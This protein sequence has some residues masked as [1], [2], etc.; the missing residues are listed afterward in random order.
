[1]DPDTLLEGACS[2]GRNHYIIHTPPPVSRHL[3]VVVDDSA[4]NGYPLSIRIPL[5]HLQS[6]TYALYP[7][8]TH[9]TIRRVFTPYHAPHTKKHFC[10][11]CGTAL[12][13]WSEETPEDAEW[14]VV[15]LSSL[16][17]ESLERLQDA[18]L[19]SAPEEASNEAVS[20]QEAPRNRTAVTRRSSDREVRGVPWFEEMV[21]GSDL[22][23]IKRRRGGKT[24]TDGRT[25]YEWE[26]VEIG[27]DEAESTAT[28]TAKRKLG[29]MG[30]EDDVEM[31]S[32]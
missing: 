27:G 11:F 23:R 25:K 10:G 13:S 21:E 3:Q 4:G 14:I 28:S 24:S 18:G 8:E 30:A 19:L 16:R 29:V 20:D 6:T 26:V 1:M 5:S 31:R 12:S 9:N 32:G 7:N 17:N 15:N 2:C 22:G